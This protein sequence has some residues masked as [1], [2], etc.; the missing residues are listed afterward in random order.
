MLE[1]TAQV[2]KNY[3]MST[4][5]YQKPHQIAKNNLHCNFYTQFKLDKTT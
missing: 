3:K 2:H 4:L 1:C 5:K